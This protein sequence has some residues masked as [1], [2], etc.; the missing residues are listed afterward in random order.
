MKTLA[1]GP[2]RIARLRTQRRRRVVGIV[3]VTILALPVA[4][5]VWLLTSLPKT[6][7]RIAVAGL[8]EAVEIIRDSRGIPH[9]HAAN[10]DD[11][12]YALG[13]VHAQDRLF[14]MDFA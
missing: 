11:A 7:G 12:F 3:L 13:F 14:Q 5:Y 1:S 8:T 10:E 2:R 6:S 9:I 4:L